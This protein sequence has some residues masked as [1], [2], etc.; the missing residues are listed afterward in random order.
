MNDL[1][2]TEGARRCAGIGSLATSDLP[3][4]PGSAPLYSGCLALSCA[5]CAPRITLYEH[6]STGTGRTGTGSLTWCNVYR[7]PRWDYARLA[8][9]APA[10]LLGVFRVRA[11]LSRVGWARR[12]SPRRTPTAPHL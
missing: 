11:R 5:H 1:G 4:W 10:G 12:R 9:R 3:V 6:A 7:G 8:N 2:T